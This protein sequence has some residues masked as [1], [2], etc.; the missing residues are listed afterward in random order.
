MNP[1]LMNIV[2]HCLRTLI[3]K[4]FGWSHKHCSETRPPSHP[5]LTILSQSDHLCDDSMLEPNSQFCMD[6]V[7]PEVIQSYPSSFHDLP[8]VMPCSAWKSGGAGE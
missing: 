4:S 8:L 6:P 1:L 7:V 5:P 3:L 2:F